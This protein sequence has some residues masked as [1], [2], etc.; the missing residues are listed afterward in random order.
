MEKDLEDCIKSEDGNCGGSSGNSNKKN[1]G[2]SDKNDDKL[3][4]ERKEKKQKLYLL[5]STIKTVILNP[6]FVPN[7]RDHL[8]KYALRFNP[9]QNTDAFTCD[10]S[11][12][13]VV[14]IMQIPDI[15]DYWKLLLLMVMFLVVT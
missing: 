4:P 12:D 10:I 1:K 5:Q 2:S 7:T 15:M 14:Q 11:E 9:G 3:S 13:I 8:Y 6:M